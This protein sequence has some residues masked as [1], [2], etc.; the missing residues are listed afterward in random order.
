MSRMRRSSMSSSGETTTPACLDQV[1]S[2]AA[3]KFRATFG[4]IA[5]HSL[6]VVVQATT[7]TKN[8]PSRYRDTAVAAPMVAGAPSSSA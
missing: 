2:D 3:V 5:L 6:A 8:T 7:V 1:R 4:G